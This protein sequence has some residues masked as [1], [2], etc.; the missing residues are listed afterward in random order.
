MDL[1]VINGQSLSAMATSVKGNFMQGLAVKDVSHELITMTIP[2]TGSKNIYPSFVDF[3]DIRPW[4]GDRVINNLGK[5]EFEIANGDFE[6][7]IGVERNDIADDNVGFYSLRFQRMGQNV[8]RFPSKTSWRYFK[9][10]FTTLGPDGQYFF[11]VD[12]PVG[13]PG[14]EVSVSNFMGGSGAPWYL[15]DNSQIFKPV[16]YQPRQEFNLVTRFNPEDPEV[17]DHKRFLFGVD[18][19]S[20]IGF[21]PFWQT[22][23]ASRQTLDAT[24]LDAATAAMNSQFDNNGE[25]L[26]VRATHLVVPPSLEQAAINLVGKAFLAGG[27]S[28]VRL[29]KLQV[30]V[31]PYLA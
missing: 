10:G 22:A 16:I 21:S 13:R 15:V 5:M 12:H 30:A 29:G 24:N 28:N 31:V 18:G 8:S 19:R 2:S 1:I 6:Q 3:G 27:E 20:G 23:F 4:I 25:P 26:E 7:T 17:F 14:S 11:D 9:N